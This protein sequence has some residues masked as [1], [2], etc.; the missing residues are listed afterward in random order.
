M[1]DWTRLTRCQLRPYVHLG[2]KLDETHKRAVFGGVKGSLTPQNFLTLARQHTFARDRPLTDIPS[3]GTPDVP[4][5]A[6]TLPSW[7]RSQ[8][9]LNGLPDPVQKTK[10]KGERLKKRRARMAGASDETKNSNTGGRR[11]KKELQVVVDH[12]KVTNA[13]RLKAPSA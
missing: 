13:P 3:A 1:V 10:V 6:R 11:E 9:V 7:L 5:T 2:V 12:A 8:M 4:Y